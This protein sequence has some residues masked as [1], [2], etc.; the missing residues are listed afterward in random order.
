MPARHTLMAI[1][2]DFDGTLASGNVQEPQFLPDVDV[3]AGDFWAE[4]S[5]LSKK[6]RADNVL[7]YMYLMLEKARAADKP[8]RLQ[9]FRQHGEEVKFFEGVP[10]WFGNINKYGK[11]NNIRLEHY[12]VSSG[13]A[14]IIEGTSIAGEFKEIYASQFMFDA[15]GVAVWPSLAVNYTTKTQYLFR[16]NKDAHDLSD[17]KKINKFVSMQ[18]RHIPFERMIY[19]GDGET[20][21]P[22]FR[23]V[24]DQGGLSI[25]VFKPRKHNAREALAPLVQD[26]RVHTVVPADYRE[27]RKL[28]QVVRAQIRLVAA[29]EAVRQAAPAP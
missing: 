13:N 3:V 23:L 5:A 4:V 16:I 7:M 29:R 12:I 1:I 2:Y 10:E 17:T 14:E 6:H 26:G 15:N 8:I 11:E 18:D 25:A 22:C 20:D 9:D 21:I 24:K 19:I 28:D 27:G